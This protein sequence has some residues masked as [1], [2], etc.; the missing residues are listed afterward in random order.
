MPNNVVFARGSLLVCLCVV[1][2]MGERSAA[3]E[4]VA[5]LVDSD[6]PQWRGPDRLGTVGGSPWPDSLETLSL[7]WSKPLGPGYSGPL[8]AGSRVLVTETVDAKTERVVAFDRELG[9]E[10]W[11]AEWPGAMS[12]PFFAKSNGDWIRC[13]PATDGQLLFAGGMRDVLVALNLADGAVVWQ[14]DFVAE[15]K[16]PLPAFGFVSSPLIDGNQLI[17]QAGGS[18]FCLDKT[19][20][21]ENWRAASDGGGMNGSAFSSPVRATIHGIPQYVVQTRTQLVGLEAKRGRVLWKQDVPAFRGMNIVTPLVRGAEV[22]TSSYGG[23]TYLYRVE[24][25][26]DDGQSGVTEVWK[27]K[28]QGY[29]S[30]PVLVGDQ[31]YIHLK[32]QRVACVDWTNGE[33]RWTSTPFGKYWSTARQ[34]DR[35]LTL[36][37]TGD[38]RLIAAHP[39][40]LKILDTSRVGDGDAWAHVAISNRDVAIRSLKAIKLYRWGAP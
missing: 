29:M 18:V 22:F 16:S 12:V 3:A 31:V 36:D 2:G 19:N 26:D 34:G 4:P 6:W 38:L 14:K 9:R 30:S 33:T 15:Y 20:G 23:A 40:K 7:T 39:E 32:S 5:A 10:L 37:E 11:K 8:I 1:A 27:N 13:T 21:S 35:L 17:V 25:P 28:A 24:T